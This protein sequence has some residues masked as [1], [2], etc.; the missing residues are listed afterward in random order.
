MRIIWRQVR[1]TITPKLLIKVQITHDFNARNFI[2][3]RE[4]QANSTPPPKEYIGMASQSHP[5]WM[6]PPQRSTIPATTTPIDHTAANYIHHLST[7]QPSLRPVRGPNPRTQPQNSQA[8]QAQQLRPSSQK[9]PRAPEGGGAL[10]KP[11]A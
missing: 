1:P 11:R 4:A 3:V 6:T 9:R 7:P 2:T 8:H 5:Q 10:K